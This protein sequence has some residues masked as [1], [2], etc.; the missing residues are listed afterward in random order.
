MKITFYDA[1]GINLS[2]I[3]FL[4][5]NYD[6]TRNALITPESITYTP[7]TELSPG[8]HAISLTVSDI[9][10]NNTTKSWSFTIAESI[11]SIERETGDINLGETI[12][13]TIDEE[14]SVQTGI[15]KIY[16]DAA[17]TLEETNL[18][19]A[20]LPI[21][22]SEIDQ[23][24]ITDTTMIITGG[25]YLNIDI[26]TLNIYTYLDITLSSNG[27]KVLE[28][29]IN[30]ITIFFKIEKT[31]ISSNNV[32]K[33]TVKLLRYKNGGWH[34][35]ATTYNHEDEDY[36]YYT[37]VTKG[38]STFTVIA[39]GKAVESQSEGINLLLIIGGIIAITILVIA[40][41]FKK[42]IL[43]IEYETDKGAF[44]LSESSTKEDDNEEET[45]KKSDFIDDDEPAEL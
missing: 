18:F 38:L 22:S 16:I 19:V 43:Y 6:I 40:V 41:L 25:G 8:S 2:S 9:L 15:D 5:N 44:Y 27:S 10:G 33:N 20:R 4:L 30:S 11:T 17:R 7:R 26:Q 3:I 32:D 36:A 42:G 35:L 23:P 37:S 31:W 39:T 45:M 14:T 13:L 34:E 12:E 21:T 29:D 24:E 1:A 28:T